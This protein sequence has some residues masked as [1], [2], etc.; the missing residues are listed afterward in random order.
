MAKPSQGKRPCCICRKWFQPDARQKGRQKTCGRPECR[1]E[2]HRRQC[3]QWNKRHR[4][5]FK[6][7][8]LSRKIEAVEQV[9]AAKPPPQRRD[10]SPILP[11]EI[12][13]DEYGARQI[14]ILHYLVSL[15]MKEVR[16]LHSGVPGI[17]RNSRRIEVVDR[18][19]FQDALLL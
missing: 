4:T 18:Y 8:Y 1:R 19:G 3:G 6:S 9:S 10:R 14:A 5:Y 16:V 17:D 15:I 13:A 11:L 7:N 2:H 12:L